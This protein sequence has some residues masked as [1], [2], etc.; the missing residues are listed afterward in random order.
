MMVT[1][2]WTIFLLIGFTATALP[3]ADSLQT[4]L[5]RIEITG[6]RAFA[7]EYILEIL[8]IRQGAA[9]SF[10]RI[11]QVLPRLIEAYQAQGHFFCEIDSSIFGVDTTQLESYLK[12]QINEGPIAKIH[13]L[14]LNGLAEP[15][16]E[17]LLHQFES[18]PGS[19]FREDLLHQDIERALVWAENTG[20]PF[21]E[22][23]IKRIEVSATRT[24]EIQLDIFLDVT[25]GSLVKLDEITVHGNE[26]TRKDVIVREIR[27]KSGRLFDQRSISKIQPRLMK[28]GFFK[29][30]NQPIVYRT[31]SGKYGLSIRIQEGNPNRFDGVIGYTPGTEKKKGYFTGLLNL[32]LGNLLGTGRQ[33]DAHW[34]KKDRDSQ[35][36][37]FHYLEPWLM[38]YPIHCGLEFQQKIQDTTYIQRDWSLDIQLPL[39]ENFTALFKIGFQQIRPDSLGI[40]LFGIPRSNTQNFTLGLFYDT[41]DDPINPRS[42]LRYQTS[43]EFGRKKLLST[44]KLRTI[45]E[46]DTKFEQKKVSVDFDWLIPLFQWQVLSLSLRGRQVTSDEAVIPITEQFRFGGTRTLRGYREEQFRGSRIAWLNFEYRYILARPSRVFLFIDSGYFSRKEKTGQRIDRFKL[47]YGFGLRL[48]TGLGMMGVDYG[49]GEGSGLLSGLVHVGLINE[50]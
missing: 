37:G 21:C 45:A 35:E 9:L 19:H 32:S 2:I 42:G 34:Q 18:R 20:Y 7:E 13:T 30:V 6:N 29:S 1:K 46:E 27:F 5:K 24:D 26:I 3:S 28:L 11:K 41:R 23:T 31:E 33:V 10:S 4:E 25:L 8:G 47:S 22:I 15:E 40:V 44:Q 17:Q 43:L 12:L 49:L 14:A 48:Q 50:F 16:K 39:S 38:G 36:L